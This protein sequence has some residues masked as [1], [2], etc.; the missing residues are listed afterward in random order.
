MWHTAHVL[1]KIGF[2]SFGLPTTFAVRSPSATIGPVAMA[3]TAI[4]VKR[5]LRRDHRD[6]PTCLMRRSMDRRIFRRVTDV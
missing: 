6:P 4:R 5:M 1:T 3:T 2:P